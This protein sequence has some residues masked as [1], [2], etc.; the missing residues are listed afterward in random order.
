MTNLSGLTRNFLTRLMLAAFLPCLYACPYSSR[1]SLDAEPQLPIEDDF[2]GKWAV[3]I[4]T[5][6]KSEIPVKL[7]ID[8]YTDYEYQLVFVGDWHL[9]APRRVPFTDSIKGTGFISQVGDKRFFNVKLKNE[10]YIAE[11][12]V[13]NGKLSLLPLRDHFTN[14]L[15]KKQTELRAELEWHYNYRIKPMYDESFCLKDME[16]VH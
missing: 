12:F 5:Y 13:K 1:F 16:R 2:M 15:I 8:K 7:I 11:T 9:M 14:K 3:M 6:D 4:Q 10:Y